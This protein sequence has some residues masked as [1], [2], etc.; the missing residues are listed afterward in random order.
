MKRKGEEGRGK[1][2]EKKKERDRKQETGKVCKE[3]MVRTSGYHTRTA[4]RNFN[5]HSSGRGTDKIKTADR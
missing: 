1:R 2:D 5:P 4:V 3:N